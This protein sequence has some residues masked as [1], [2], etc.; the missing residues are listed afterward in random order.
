MRMKVGIVGYGNLGKGAE[1]AV[2]QQGDMQI[3][4]LFSGREGLMSASRVRVYPMDAIFDLRKYLDVLILCGGSAT[5]LPVQS[6]ALA[7]EFAIVDSFD[8]HER[9]GEHIAACHNEKHAAILCAGW[10]PG[11]FSIQRVLC[12][13][14]FPRSQ[15][16]TFWGPGVSQGHS[17]A[18]R[19]IEGV[20]D[21]RQYTIPNEYAL[22]KAREGKYILKQKM[23]RRVCHVATQPGADQE[24]I[25]ETIVNMPHYFAPYETEVHFVP[26]EELGKSL[27]HGGAV[28]GGEGQMELSLKLPSNP[29]FTGA[30]L[31]AYARAAWRLEQEGNFGA[32]TPLDV[33]IGYLCPVDKCEYL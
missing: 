10:D 21:A 20:V 23:H 12:K 2:L 25:R 31:T 22:Q 1:A 11:L 16:H 8:D 32:K 5:D 30:I 27:A 6:P 33:P 3:V 24:K 14:I 18:L 17:H 19:Q 15:I 29:L 4:G 7:K 28:I 13:S 9:A 26:R